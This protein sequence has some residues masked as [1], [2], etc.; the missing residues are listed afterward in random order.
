MRGR[1]RP[2]R[3]KYLGFTMVGAEGFE[4]SFPSDHFALSSL[5]L[6][7]KPALIQRLPNIS[8]VP[9]CLYSPT[10]GPHS[11]RSWYHWY[12]LGFLSRSGVLLASC[13]IHSTTG[14]LR[15]AHGIG[16]RSDLRPEC[17]QSPATIYLDLRFC[18]IPRCPPNL[19]VVSMLAPHFRSPPYEPREFFG[20]RLSRGWGFRLAS[21]KLL[22]RRQSATAR[23]RLIL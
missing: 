9:F 4:V 16:E 20:H 19:L 21:G 14:L 12:H 22:N 17:S 15:F 5:G 1:H 2:Y 8:D 18:T 13:S 6:E 3:L 7:G 23:L 11:A 10:D